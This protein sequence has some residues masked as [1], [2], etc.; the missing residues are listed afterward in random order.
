MR[1]INEEEKKNNDKIVIF[2]QFLLEP[3]TNP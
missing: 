3:V 2:L 1:Q